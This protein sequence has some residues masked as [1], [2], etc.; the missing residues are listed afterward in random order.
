MT[1]WALVAMHTI[2]LFPCCGSLISKYTLVAH[3]NLVSL[4]LLSAIFQVYSGTWALGVSW[5]VP[6]SEPQHS[7][8]AEGLGHTLNCHVDTAVACLWYWKQV[9][10]TDSIC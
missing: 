5:I 9:A 1:S 6:S 2:I 4:T 10:T 8:L 7:F 3:I